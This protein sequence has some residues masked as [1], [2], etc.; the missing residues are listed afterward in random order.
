MKIEWQIMTEP[1][2][3]SRTDAVYQAEGLA[4]YAE[5]HGEFYGR[6]KL[7]EVVTGKTKRLNVADE[8]V[9]EKVK[10]ISNSE[11]LDSLFEAL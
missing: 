9:R 5:K 1:H 3:I 11:D 4:R 8:A 6:I 7:I 2:D 10:R